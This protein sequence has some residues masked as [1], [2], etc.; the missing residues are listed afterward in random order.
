LLE[1]L[2]ATLVPGLVVLETTTAAAGPAV[3]LCTPDP[4]RG[5]VPADFP[6]D[7]CIGADSVTLRNDRGE[8][9]L[10]VTTGA[11]GPPDTVHERGSGRDQPGGG[12]AP[13]RP[14]GA[15][16]AVGAARTRALGEW[17][18]AA[19]ADDAGV[20]GATLRLDLAALPP[21][22]APALPPAPAVVVPSV[23]R[24]PSARVPAPAPAPPPAPLPAPP[25]APLPDL[26]QPPQ[27]PPVQHGEL[28]DWLEDLLDRAGKGKG[29]DND[30]KGNNGNGNGHEGKG[31]DDD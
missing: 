24:A 25:P 22:P 2:T 30:G 31:R 21:A 28:P 3:E 11:L 27:L 26:P 18:V 7:A 5:G 19:P 4:G 8:P 29:K 23:P 12:H 10:V 14:R 9:V 1:L 16:G 13:D 17:A 20:S 6:L 15:P